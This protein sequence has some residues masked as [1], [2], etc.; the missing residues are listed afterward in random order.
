[1]DSSDSKGNLLSA[2]RVLFGAEVRADEGFLS[3]LDRDVLRRRFRQRAIEVHPDRASVLRRHPAALAEAFKQVE[4]AYRT[5]RDHLAAGTA[6]RAGAGCEAARPN[7]P[8]STRPAR[9]SAAATATAGVAAGDHF[10]SGPIPDRTLRLGEFLYYSGRISWSQLIRAL[11][12]QARQRPRFGQVAGSCGYLT[13]ELVAAVLAQR[14]AREK[15]G[16]AALRLRL[17]TSLQR[18]LVLQAQQRG[19]RR[20]GD[21][22]RQTGLLGSGD[23]E[24]FG[25]AVRVHNARVAFLRQPA[26]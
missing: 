22:F 19:H 6:A 4:A 2:C 20:I 17:L 1:M 7:P 3:R 21:Y 25:R 16:E 11:V 9:S 24:S 14:Q 26:G 10:W 5:I 13:P 18:Q 23:I 15:I 8:P 12:W